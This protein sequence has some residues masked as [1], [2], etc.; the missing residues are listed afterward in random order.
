[1]S[2]ALNSL[3]EEQSAEPAEAKDKALIIYTEWAQP[4]DEGGFTEPQNGR[5]VTHHFILNAAISICLL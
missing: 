2:T 4:F 5:F 3:N 1:V